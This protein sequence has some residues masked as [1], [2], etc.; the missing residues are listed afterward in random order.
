MLELQNVT[1]RYGKKTVLDDVSIQF[2]KGEITCLLG[3]NG[4]GKSTTM[5]A[6]MRLVPISK[7]KILVDGEPIT[8]Q[9]INK[10]AYIPD[11]PI[12]D[13]GW[14]IPQNLSFAQVFYKNFNLEKAERMLKFF[15]VPTDKKLKELSKGNLA[16][17]NI[18]VGMCQDAPYLLLDE[19]FSGIDVFT[20]QSFINLLKSEF[21][22]DGQTVIIT[23]H[24]IDE[25]Q[26]IADH[27]VL[28][29]DGQV[30]AS[31]SKEEAQN[32][33]LSIVDKMRTLYSEV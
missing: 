23:T 24:E 6:I 13:L 20:R 33:G 5:K 3:L 14:T 27:I 22:E 2:K 7:G 12:H 17:F 29:E 4:V 8:Q 21:L 11:I 26:D 9:N 10:I 30:F 25:I 15:K 1:K 18:I 16:R 32:E 19:P 28:L 31:F